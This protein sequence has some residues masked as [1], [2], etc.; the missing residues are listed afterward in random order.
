MAKALNC[1]E[2]SIR[3]DL[4]IYS[5]GEL[6]QIVLEY[7]SEWYTPERTRIEMIHKIFDL[8][9]NFELTDNQS[10]TIGCIICGDNL[11]NGDNI[12]LYCGHKFHSSC[13]IQSL[14]VRCANLLIN[15]LNNKDI[16]TIV[17][18]SQCPECNSITNSYQFNKSDI[19][20]NE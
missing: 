7:D 11:T 6:A 2:K 13:V 8:W 1:I 3:P 15:G 16:A 17:L 4:T 5:D 20:N 18:N 10:N 12:T 14:L 9:A 19:T